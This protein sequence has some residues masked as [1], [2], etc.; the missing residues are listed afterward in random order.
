MNSTTVPLKRA[1]RGAYSPLN[2]KLSSPKFVLG[3]MLIVKKKKYVL[4]KYKILR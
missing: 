2:Y 1:L 4:I 3:T